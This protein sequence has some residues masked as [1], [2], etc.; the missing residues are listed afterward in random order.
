[1]GATHAA[2]G[3][4]RFAGVAGWCMLTV[5]RRFFRHGSES[6][7]YTQILLTAGLTIPTN[8]NV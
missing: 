1:M 2:A 5:H 8:T 3:R 7:V 4:D 6:M